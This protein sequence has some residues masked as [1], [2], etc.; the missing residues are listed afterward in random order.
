MQDL[1]IA[2]F[3]GVKGAA[4]LLLKM[5]RHDAPHVKQGREQVVHDGV[6]VV[7]LIF[8]VGVHDEPDPGGGRNIQAD[9]V[10]NSLSCHV[11][12]LYILVRWR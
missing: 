3:H 6:L 12:L 10:Q 1:L 2:F 7:R 5:G 4:G 8:C 9:A 11:M